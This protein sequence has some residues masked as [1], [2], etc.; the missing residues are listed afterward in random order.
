MNARSTILRCFPS[1]ALLATLLLPSAIAAAQVTDDERARTHFLAGSSYYDQRRFL[2]AA[3]QFRDAYRL[4][5]RTD[6]LKNVAMAY[7]HADEPGLAAD[8]L[9]EWLEAAP[10]DAPDRRTQ[11]TRMTQLRAAEE[12]RV[13]AAEAAASTPAEAPTPEEAP[14]RLSG[15]GIGGIATMG[16]GVAAAGVAIGTGIASNE[17][18][19]Q[20]ESRCTDGVFPPDLRT[21]RDQGERLA[22]VSTIGTFVSIGAAGAGL[23]MLLLDLRTDPQDGREPALTLAPGPGDLGL[24]A[25]LL[26]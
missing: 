14:S 7:E 6:L 20:L 10:A 11:E 23:V 26:F 5:G 18:L 1:L 12:A 8:A 24:A 19:D 3:E 2:E 13:R 16:F 21:T 17:R 25:Q 4:S 15:L 22:L 9:A